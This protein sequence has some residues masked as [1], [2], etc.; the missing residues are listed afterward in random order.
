[1]KNER[2]LAMTDYLLHCGRKTA[3]ELASHFEVSARTIYRDIDSLCTAGV[4]IVAEAGTGGG[5]EIEEG[6]R[7]DRSFLSAEEIADLRSLLEGLAEAVKDRHLQRSL[8]KISSLGPRGTELARDRSGLPP[9][10]IATLSPWGAAGGDPTM[11]CELRRAIAERRVVSF[12]YVDGESRETVRSAEP[13]SIVMGG[14]VWYLHAWCRLRKSFRLFKIARM[15]RLR[16]ECERFDPYARVPVPSP[17]A[18]SDSTEIPVSIVIS[19]EARIKNAVEESF[20]GAG[21]GPD[22]DGRWTY[23]FR[24]PR[25]N[26]LLHSLLY[27]GPGLRVVEPADLREELA[28]AASEIAR[29]NE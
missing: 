20:P 3:E 2:L 1:M 28:R 8:G 19:V 5:Y 7:I 25:G 11:V 17:F 15:S 13:F 21:T 22:Q 18:F 12:G 29:A 27:F 14:A 24:W 6:Y 23:R 16:V 9:P 10:L 26:Y 4:P